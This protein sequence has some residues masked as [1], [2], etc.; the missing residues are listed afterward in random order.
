MLFFNNGT[1]IFLSYHNDLFVANIQT[2]LLISNNIKNNDANVNKW[3]YLTEETFKFA[4]YA[5]Y[6]FAKGDVKTK[7]Y[8]MSK[9]GNNLT[10]KDGK[11]LLDQSKAFFL[12]E[13]GYNSVKEM[14]VSLE[15][16]KEIITPTQMLSLEPI[17]KSWRRMQ[18]SNLRLP[19]GR[20]VFET[21]AVSHLANPPMLKLR[22]INPPFICMIKL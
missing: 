18:D 14:A 10:L 9:L 19:Y 11:L 7:T 12:I 16:N 17:C 15:P 8:I 20:T 5:R 3:V 1:Q 4:C 21:V 2:C 6:W 13:K 22:R